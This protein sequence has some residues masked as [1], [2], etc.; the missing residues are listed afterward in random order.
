[1]ETQTIS[2]PVWAPGIVWIILS[3]GSF[4]RFLHVCIDQYS[5]GDLLHVSASLFLFRSLLILCPSSF[6]SLWILIIFSPYTKLSTPSSPFRKAKSSF[7]FPLSSLCPGNSP[8]QL[9]PS[10]CR[11]CLICFTFF[12]NNL[13][14]LSLSNVWKPLFNMFC[15]VV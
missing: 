2:S 10:N 15:F 14:E 13:F 11:A 5:D 6:S 12:I 7:G 4:P 8:R 1:M 3:G 9:V